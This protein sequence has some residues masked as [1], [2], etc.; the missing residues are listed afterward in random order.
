MVAMS[1]GLLNGPALKAHFLKLGIAMKLMDLPEVAGNRSGD[2]S[3]ML[4]IRRP[5]NWEIAAVSHTRICLTRW[6]RT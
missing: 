2:S 4:P 1:I 5:S 3:L 6:T